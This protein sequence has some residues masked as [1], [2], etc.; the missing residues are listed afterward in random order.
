MC[1][2]NLVPNIKVSYSNLILGLCTVQSESDEENFILENA[3]CK[4]KLPI[5]NKMVTTRL[6]RNHVGKDISISH[7]QAHRNRW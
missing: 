2:I 6:V 3:K 1:K 5:C 7:L 4:F